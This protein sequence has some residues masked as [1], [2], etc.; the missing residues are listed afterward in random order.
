MVAG[1]RCLGES[2]HWKQGAMRVEGCQDLKLQIPFF[3]S[4]PKDHWTLK[5]GYFED[6]TPAIQVQTLPLEGPRSLRPDEFGAIIRC[7]S[8]FEKRKV[9][10]LNSD[11]FRR[12]PDSI[13]FP[14]CP[15][16]ATRTPWEILLMEEI[17]HHLGYINLV[18]NGINYISTGA[19]FSS[20][21]SIFPPPWAP[22]RCKKNDRQ[23][24]E[25][26]QKGFK[27][28]QV[29]NPWGGTGYMWSGRGVENFQSWVEDHHSNT[30]SVRNQVDVSE[31][32][33][34]FGR[35]VVSFHL[36]RRLKDIIYLL[37]SCF[38]LFPLVL[39]CFSSEQVR[40]S[41]G[42]TEHLPSWSHFLCH[43]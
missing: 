20:I 25:S 42:T 43:V 23:F 37:L 34:A 14:H 15:K 38:G 32:L 40:F 36:K 2:P 11:S 29:G 12:L 16:L 13:P 31:Y 28:K 27:T 33:R 5:T 4:P 41:L 18:N 26:K 24:E 6:P 7:F 1:V 19:G 3:S 8:I 21:N 35:F 9:P 30:I 10:N 17:L 39:P 22:K